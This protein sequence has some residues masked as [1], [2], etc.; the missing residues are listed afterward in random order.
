MP[1]TQRLTLGLAFVATVIGVFLVAQSTRST[2]M[3]PL[4]TGLEP[5]AASEVTAEL[6]ARGVA[7]QLDAGGRI[8]EVPAGEVHQLRI[9]LAGA[10]LPG[11]VEGFE[12]IDNL[13][14]LGTSFEQQVAYQRALEGELEQTITAIDT[15][16]SAD[17]NLVLPEYDLFPDDNRRAS[18]AVV[19]DTGSAGVGPM[20]VQAVTN[21]VASS[22]EGLTTDAV[23][24]V[25]QTGRVLSAPGDDSMSFALENDSWARAR[26]QYESE[27]ESELEAMLTN[28]VGPGGAV[29]NVAAD[30][31]FDSGSTTT[32]EMVPLTDADGNQLIVTERTNEEFVRDDSQF[33]DEGGQ[34]EIELPEDIDLDGDGNI[35]ETVTYVRNE[36]EKAGAFSTRTQVIESAPGTVTGLSVSVLLDE[37][38]VDAGRLADIEN[39]VQNAIRFDPERGDAVAVTV[40]PFDADVKASLEAAAAA[41]EAPAGGGLD[42]VGLLRTIGTIVVALVVVFLALRF[43]ARNPRRKVEPVDPAELAAAAAA[44][45]L[46]AGVVPEAGRGNAA[47]LASSADDGEGPP[48]DERL[49]AL[50]ANQ[51]DDVAD[52]LRTW[53]QDDGEQP[54]LL[55]NSRE[56]EKVPV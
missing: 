37:E 48:A 46:E 56:A 27:V 2:P 8:I 6:E 18:A 13:G 23:S 19:I 14:M 39:L 29:V 22:V 4:F 24:V 47:L 43:L 3:V 31:S 1:P 52:I 40:M 15:V 21:L 20:Q 35:D 10:D 9:D 51:T 11:G 53:L 45:A 7:Y 34:L 55:S 17:V 25:D 42:L 41:A 12:L 28:L 33:V 50:I 30:M 36:A 54:T 44:A 5:S 49:Q 16:R 26:L 32:E 38:K